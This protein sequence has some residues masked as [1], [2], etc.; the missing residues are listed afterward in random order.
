MFVFERLSTTR[1]HPIHFGPCVDPAS[2]QRPIAGNP[3]SDPGYAS[4]PHVTMACEKTCIVLVNLAQLDA[5]HDI[6]TRSICGPDY[7]LQ[8]VPEPPT[9]L[10][11]GA[12]PGVAV[13]APSARRRQA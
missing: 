8:P 13:L 6:D 9:A 3:V 7:S 4:K 2:S 5:S 10:L 1:L 12:G 11:L